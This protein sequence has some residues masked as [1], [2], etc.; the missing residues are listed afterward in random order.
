MKL[1]RPIP[2]GIMHDFPKERPWESEG[3]MLP[4]AIRHRSPPAGWN[5][6]RIQAALQTLGA[7]SMRVVMFVSPVDRESLVQAAEKFQ[8]NNVYIIPTAAGP[9]YLMRTKKAKNLKGPP[10]SFRLSWDDMRKLMTGIMRKTP[11]CIKGNPRNAL[12]VA[13]FILMEARSIVVTTR[14]LQIAY[15]T[16]LTFLDVGEDV[17]MMQVD[18]K[19]LC[20][21]RGDLSELE[22]KHPNRADIVRITRTTL[23]IYVNDKRLDEFFFIP[24]ENILGMLAK[25]EAS[26]A[27]LRPFIDRLLHVSRKSSMSMVKSSP[28]AHELLRH[29]L[30]DDF[31][32]WSH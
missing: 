16:A 23:G 4:K 12:L 19:L 13:Y 1:K 9:G 3:P 20:K 10:I 22:K 24:F 28:D 5:T 6:P 30:D 17:G 8:E 29:I 26:H 11:G 32:D 25:R 18:Y 31:G 7:L 14:L 27:T 15:P 2:T 21:N